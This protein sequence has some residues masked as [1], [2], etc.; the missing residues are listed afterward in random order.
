M[1]TQRPIITVKELLSRYAAGERDFPNI[2]IGL[3]E[4]VY[5]RECDLSGINLEGSGLICKLNGAVF[6][7]S[8]LR[9]SDWEFAIAENVDFSGSDLT[10]F[11][12]PQG[13]VLRNCQ[14]R[15]TIWGQADLWNTKFESCDI[16][17]AN[18]GDAKFE[19]VEFIDCTY[20]GNTNWSDYRGRD[21]RWKPTDHT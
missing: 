1:D 15:N 6:R 10:G 3:G 21:Y 8:N 13:C 17:G 11:I 20:D 16:R 19:G 14:F 4:I 2:F 9:R 7:D 12:S 18:F 5:F